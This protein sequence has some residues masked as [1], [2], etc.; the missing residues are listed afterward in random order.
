MLINILKTRCTFSTTCDT[1]FNAQD[2][3][4]TYDVSPFKMFYFLVF[5]YAFLT[6]PNLNMP[7]NHKGLKHINNILV[8]CIIIFCIIKT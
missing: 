1:Y 2:N 4:F 3:Y 5:D 8:F 6:L 7:F